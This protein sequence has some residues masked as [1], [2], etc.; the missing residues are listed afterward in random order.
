MCFNLLCLFGA[1]KKIITRI[2]ITIIIIGII[3]K[4]R[5]IRSKKKENYLHKKNLLSP[6]KIYIY[7]WLVILLWKWQYIV[8]NRTS[9]TSHVAISDLLPPWTLRRTISS[10]T[11]GNL[12]WI[13]KKLCPWG[14][15]SRCPCCWTRLDSQSFNFALKPAVADKA[16]HSSYS[17]ALVS[18]G[19]A[20]L[21]W[22]ISTVND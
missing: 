21:Q 4:N 9:W 19:A 3:K 5:R 8:P 10:G 13:K 22:R 2:E 6:L 11:D 20:V 16:M 7:T 14:T 18:N 1:S 12:N 17:R 15:V